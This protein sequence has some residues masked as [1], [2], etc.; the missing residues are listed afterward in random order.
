VVSPDEFFANRDLHERRIAAARGIVGPGEREAPLAFRFYPALDSDGLTQIRD[1]DDELGSAICELVS[2]R[3]ITNLPWFMN[4]VQLK[5]FTTLMLGDHAGTGRALAAYA[6]VVDVVRSRISADERPPDDLT[7]EQRAHV[8]ERLTQHFEMAD[9]VGF[10]LLSYGQSHE[11]GDYR[12]DAKK[13]Y[14]E[15]FESVKDAAEDFYDE[16]YRRRGV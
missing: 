16:A 6:A 15:Q 1:F 3:S 11:F 4:E 10:L 14:A 7:D 9:Y 12:A 2:S 13:V 8:G 5:I